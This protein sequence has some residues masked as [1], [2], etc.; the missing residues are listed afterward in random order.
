MWQWRAHSSE[1]LCGTWTV[2]AAAPEERRRKPDM[3]V[4]RS[5]LGATRGDPPL[6]SRAKPCSTPRRVQRNTDTETR[7]VVYK[8]MMVLRRAVGNGFPIWLWTSASSG[9]YATAIQSGKPKF[10]P[11]A[12]VVLVDWKIRFRGHGDL[13]LCSSDTLGLQRL[14]TCAPCGMQPGICGEFVSRRGVALGACDIRASHTYQPL[15]GHM[16]GRPPSISCRRAGLGWSRSGLAIATQT[17]KL[18]GGGGDN[19]GRMGEKEQG[20]QRR[21]GISHT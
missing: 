16:R 4:T 20:D 3:S 7:R 6:Q 14:Q 10:V 2:H 11:N 17:L 21:D 8:V 19:N 9:N 18:D 5:M 13:R 1:V 12:M 15:P